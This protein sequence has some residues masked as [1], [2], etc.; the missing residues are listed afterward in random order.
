MIHAGH[1]VT[2]FEAS[3]QTGGL[4]AGFKEPHWDW[5]VEHFYHHWFEGDKAL[6][7]LIDELGFSDRLIYPKPVSVMYHK[8]KFYPFDSIPA[9]IKYPPGLGF[10]LTKIRFGLVGVYLRLTKNWRAF[11]KNHD[12]SLDAKMG[13]R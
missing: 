9:A 7:G 8:G 4:A 13:G 6:R 5:S 3:H 2:I 11:E 1:D 12:R 10:G